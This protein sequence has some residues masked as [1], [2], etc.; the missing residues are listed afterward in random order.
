MKDLIARLLGD[1]VFI[2]TVAT[3]A[4]PA[5]AVF[6]IGL[7]V[8]IRDGVYVPQELQYLEWIGGGGAV[9]NGIYGIVHAMLAKRP[10]AQAPAAAGGQ[11]N[12]Q[13]P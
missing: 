5:L 13:Q 6:F 2:A 9:A 7:N 1:N 12:V 11:A 10:N 8:L 3:I 4:L